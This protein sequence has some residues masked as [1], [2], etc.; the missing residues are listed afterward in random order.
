MIYL[1]NIFGISI[2]TYLYACKSLAIQLQHINH[3]VSNATSTTHLGPL[4]TSLSHQALKMSFP[5]FPRRLQNTTEHCTLQ[6]PP[7]GLVMNS[8]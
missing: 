6:S 5:Q 2:P 1:V 7:K 8:G 3:A 4:S